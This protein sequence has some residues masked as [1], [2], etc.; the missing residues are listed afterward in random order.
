MQLRVVQRTRCQGILP[1]AWGYSAGWEWTR[2]SHKTAILKNSHSAT[3]LYDCSTCCFLRPR[4]LVNSARLRLYTVALAST[5]RTHSAKPISGPS[6]VLVRAPCQTRLPPA[7][8]KPW[9][10]TLLSVPSPSPLCRW[11]PSARSVLRCNEF[12]H[13]VKLLRFEVAGKPLRGD[14]APRPDFRR[15]GKPCPI[16]RRATGK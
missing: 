6:P 11:L 10:F 5:G 16:T 15:S 7:L 14:K 8:H 13:V 9:S 12:S 1:R 2:P 4:P 3:K